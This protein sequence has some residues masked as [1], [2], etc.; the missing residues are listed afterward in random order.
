MR[1]RSPEQLLIIRAAKEHMQAMGIGW[2]EQFHHVNRLIL[3][4]G[5]NPDNR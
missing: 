5:F 1:V 3:H 4:W 2:Y